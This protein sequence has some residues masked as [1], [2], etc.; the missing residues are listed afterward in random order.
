M[1]DKLNRLWHSLRFIF[2]LIQGNSQQAKTILQ[3]IKK[4]QFP[5]SPLEQLFL[6]KLEIEYELKQKEKELIKLKKQL[7]S[8]SIQLSSEFEFPENNNLKPDLTLINSITDKFKLTNHDQHLIQCTGIDREIFDELESNLSNF[9]QHEFN[10]MSRRQNFQ[11]SLNEAIDDIKSLKTGA[12]PQYCYEF[13]PHIYLMRYFLDNVYCAYLAWF[14]IY[15]SGILPNDINI[16]DLASGPGTVISG[17][18]IFLRS[19]EKI[20]NLSQLKIT[21]Y[22]LEK[23]DKF[24]YRGLQFWRKYVEQQSQ[25]TNTYFRFETSDL[26]NPNFNVYK[27]PQH[28][29][30]FIVISHCLFYKVETRK[31]AHANLKKIFSHCLKANGYVL[32]IIQDKKLRKAY[33]G[34]FRE[35]NPDELKMI[36]KLLQELG[37]NLVW[38]NYLTSTGLQKFILTSDFGKFARENLPTQTYM[39]PLFRQYFKLNYDLNYTLDDYIILAK[40]P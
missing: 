10:Q 1:I 2:C 7:K 20:I 30:N 29:F 27:L 9:L 16:L 19:S 8:N 22:S 21:Y 25:P 24:Q 35:N 34:K 37:L 18:D 40:R 14:L 5:L 6:E 13:S 39:S 11:A 23:Q 4:L 12:D 3:H 15:Q 28:S 17:L 32:Q 31:I 33:E 26:L 38:Y 36:Q